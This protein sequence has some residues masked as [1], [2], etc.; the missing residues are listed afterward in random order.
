MPSKRTTI[1]CIFL[2]PKVVR[3]VLLLS[4]N[5]HNAVCNLKTQDQDTVFLCLCVLNLTFYIGLFHLEIKLTPNCT[6][7]PPPPPPPGR[8]RDGQRG[9]VVSLVLN[10]LWRL[11]RRRMTATMLV[12]NLSLVCVFC[13]QGPIAI[14][15][16]SKYFSLSPLLGLISSSESSDADDSDP[17]SSNSGDSTFSEDINKMVKVAWFWLKSHVKQDSHFNPSTDSYLN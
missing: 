9:V 16:V 4:T 7:L 12:R 2:P 13:S 11:S 3:R 14:I 5:R 8:E 1:K 10:P 17:E 6:C 15:V